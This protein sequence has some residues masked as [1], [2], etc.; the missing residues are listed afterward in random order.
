M[1]RLTEVEKK[2]YNLWLD[3]LDNIGEVDTQLAPNITWPAL[4]SDVFG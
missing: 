3:Y 1:G 4:I 2:Q